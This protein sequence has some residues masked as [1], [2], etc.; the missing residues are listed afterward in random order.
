MTKIAINGFGRTPR[1][2]LRNST[3]QVGR[4]AKI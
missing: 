2:F 1:K 3:G 4:L